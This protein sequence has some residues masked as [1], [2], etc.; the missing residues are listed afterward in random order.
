ML[1][2][3]AGHDTEWPYTRAYPAQT[4]VQVVEATL[5]MVPLGLLVGAIGYALS[6]W[7][8]AAVDTGLVSFLLVI[9]FVISF[10]GPG[11]QWPDATLRL[12]PFYYYG[13]PVLNGLQVVNILV[14][15]I[16]AAAALAIAATRFVRKDIQV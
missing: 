13:T 2:A 4:Y 5:A 9:W 12:S 14:I 3:M 6:G 15:L 1:A 8:A 16:V 10:V 7:L 11:L